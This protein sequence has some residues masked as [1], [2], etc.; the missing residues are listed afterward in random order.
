MTAWEDLNMA[1]LP[2]SGVPSQERYTAMRDLKWSPAEK[3]VARKAFDLA[4]QRELAA[5][6]AEAKDRAAKIEQPS[7]LWN[8]E[9]Y[10]TQRRQHIDRQ[11]DYRYSVLLMVFAN[12]VRQGRLS[13]HE[14]HGLSQNKLD[15]IRQCAK[16]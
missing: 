4:L 9:R 11:Y 6:T 1:S 5:V 7:D 8:L 16:L 13:E 12:L 3:T 2:R 10:L 15:S 14:L